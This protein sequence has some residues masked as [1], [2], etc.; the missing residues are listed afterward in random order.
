MIR[1]LNWEYWPA[2]IANLPV[3][4]FWLYF[5]ARARHLFFFSAANPAIE[6]G[7]LLGESKFSIL[8]QLSPAFKPATL[9]V[10][11][12]TAAGSLLS[13]MRERGIEFPV[14][15]KPNVGER[16]RGV[17]KITDEQGL[18][19]YLSRRPVDILVQT[20]VAAP[21]EFSVL[22][23]R[24]P[25][26][27]TGHI[28]SLCHKVHLHVVGD[29][30]RTVKE[31]VMD[32]PRALFQWEAQSKNWPLDQVPAAGEVVPL[33]PLGNH[34][35][36]AM[37]V[38]ANQHID[39]QLV[40]VFD[41]ISRGLQGVH[42]VRFDL[43]VRSLAALRAGEGI[44]V[45]EINGVGGEPAH[46]YDPGYSAAKAY[47]DLFRHWKTIYE[48]ARA[49]NR[50]GVPYMSLAEGLTRFRAYLRHLRHFS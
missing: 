11:A 33:C 25:G 8:E 6:T 4:A 38:N 26:E 2:N 12:G 22:Y 7:G 40:R 9:F 1:L 24:F 31:L 30:R 41:N 37:F 34:S 32:S 21:E 20:F 42:L 23:H 15:A 50:L 28:S 3:I 47:R 19:D 45:V 13:M 27:Q 29:G 14:I 49:V 36:G 35:R 39:E 16:G 10:P 18:A 5:S 48:V 43:K 17:E 44:S 46:I